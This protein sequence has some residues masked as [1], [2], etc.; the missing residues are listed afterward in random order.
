[1]SV[2]GSEVYTVYIDHS[3]AT[4]MLNPAKSGMVTPMF[5]ERKDPAYPRSYFG[6]VSCCVPF[7]TA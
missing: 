5:I 2:T 6:D 7:S 3:I 1:M 4:S